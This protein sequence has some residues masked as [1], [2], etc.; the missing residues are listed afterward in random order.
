MHDPNQD[1]L[2][3]RRVAYFRV[4]RTRLG[5]VYERFLT[6]TLTP[7]GVVLLVECR[8]TWPTIRVGDRHVFQFGAVG[9]MTPQEYHDGSPRLADYLRRYRAGR[10]RWEAPTPDGESPEAEWGFDDGLRA[11]VLAFARRHG[12]RVRRLVFDDPQDLSPLVADLYRW[13]YRQRGLPDDRLL[14]ESFILLEPWWTLR[15][16]RT[17]RRGSCRPKSLTRVLQATVPGACRSDPQRPTNPRART[18][19]SRYD[20][21]RTARAR[22][23]PAQVAPPGARTTNRW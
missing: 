9:G 15:A 16:R 10:T 11:D 13:W 3:L 22:F 19:P 1:R 18:A 12:Y 4:K 21:S 2:T 7:G 8:Q 17:T 5:T 20:V 6:Q 23:S 14:V